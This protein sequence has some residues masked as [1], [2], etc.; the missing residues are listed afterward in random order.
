MMRGPFGPGTIILGGGALFLSA[1]LGV[2][3]LLP[4]DWAAAADDRIDAAGEEIV[5]LLDSPEGWRRWTVWPD[6]TTRSGPA[7]GAGA[8]MS[9]DDRDLGSGSFRIDAVTTVAVTYSVEVAGAGSAI[10]RTHGSVSLTPDGAGTRVV[11]REAGDLG[12]NPIMGFWALS[13]E[14]AQSAEMEKSLRRLAEV[15][16]GQPVGGVAPVGAAAPID[17]ERSDSSNQVVR[18]DSAPSR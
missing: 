15:L 3:F 4:S 5:S 13:M 14:R 10:M 6:S 2:G 9:W 11:W 1:L 12:R 16:L 8:T 17:G 7:R 18:S